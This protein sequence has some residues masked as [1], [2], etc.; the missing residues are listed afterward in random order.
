M[1]SSCGNGRPGLVKATGKV[2]LDGQ[3]LEGAKVA[4]QPVT[5]DAKTAYQ[6]PS[7]AITNAAGEFIPQTYL[8]DDG[9]PVGKYRVAVLK[10]EVVGQLPPG[11]LE[12]QPELFNVK[13]KWITPRSVSLAETSGIEVEVTSSGFQPD[14]IALQS[15]ATPEIELTG[16]QARA[17]EP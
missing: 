8:K 1:M 11:Y 9:I 5:A 7:S 15:A 4:L 2:T 10:R 3:P 6:R 12:D 16:P 13:Y 17:D 14:V